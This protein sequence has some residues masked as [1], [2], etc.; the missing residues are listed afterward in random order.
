MTHSQFPVFKN[1]INLS[2]VFGN[3]NR[4]EHV[5]IVLHNQKG[6]YWL[7]AKPKF[8]PPGI[9]RLVGG[10]VEAGESPSEAAIREAA[11]ELQIKISVDDI[12]PLAKIITTG[13]FKGKTFKNST[14]LFEYIVADSSQ[15]TPSDDIAYLQKMTIDE[16]QQQIE[17]YQN[18]SANDWFIAGDIYRH[19]WRDYGQ[20]YG[21]I[22]QV[23]LDLTKVTEA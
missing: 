7:G 23:A 13:E 5:L 11:E 2:A 18:L 19:C 22:H 4:S 10:G 16:L 21:F 6:D 8:Y 20:M 12:K 1:H 15:L 14:H 3:M 17:N 9:F